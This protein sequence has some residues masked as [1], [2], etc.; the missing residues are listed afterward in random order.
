[1]DV[2]GADPD[3][4]TTL[5]ASEDSGRLSGFVYL[6]RDGDG[7]RGDRDIGVPGVQVSLTGSSADGQSIVQYRLT[8]DDGSFLFGGL[9]S[10]T[11]QLV[12]TQPEAL[13]DG[14][15][16]TAFSGAVVGSD[17]FTNLAPFAVQL[18]V[19][20]DDATV[21]YTLDGSE[22]TVTTGLEYTGAMTI[23]ATTV[24]RAA[25]FR[26]RPV[27]IF[28]ERGADPG[29]P[30]SWGIGDVGGSPDRWAELVDGVL[31]EGG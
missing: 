25:A 12:E 1:V 20:T 29:L 13:L 28:R 30:E 15:E 26:E 10:R 31:A 7:T 11:Y 4:L 19:A 5:L 16:S 27:S 6:D 21:R 14:S 23:S 3:A 22:P 9:L 2:V 8:A 17:Q 24:L 18:A